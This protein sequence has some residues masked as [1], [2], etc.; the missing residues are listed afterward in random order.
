MGRPN[1]CLITDEGREC[2]K[3]SQFKPWEDY[4]KANGKS[5]VNNRQSSCKICNRKRDNLKRAE[6]Q[7]ARGITDKGKPCEQC[8]I[9]K[10]WEDFPAR[11][12]SKN[13]MYP[14]LCKLC[15]RDNANSCPSAYQSVKKTDWYRHKGQML[16]SNWR[17]RCKK[18][19]KTKLDQVPMPKDI[20]EWLKK[21]EPFICHYSGEKLTQSNVHFD[22]KHPISR[23]GD[24]HLNNIVPT[25]KDMNELK[26]EMLENDFK[27]LVALMSTWDDK[28]KALINT[29]RRSRLVWGRRK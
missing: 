3:C 7:K 10:P 17:E 20:A 2:S 25:S 27:E 16:R 1:T 15:K 19:D 22:H 11:K 26:G 21:Q 13:N 6:I 5:N 24:Y 12:N 9:F 14:K 23:G 29:L 28:G 8:N 4:N 18:N